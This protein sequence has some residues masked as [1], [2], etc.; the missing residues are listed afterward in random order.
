MGAALYE[1]LGINSP[2][3]RRREHSFLDEIPP[4]IGEQ[5]DVGCAPAKTSRR[6]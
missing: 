5:M 2:F 1:R 6:A 3:F 4:P